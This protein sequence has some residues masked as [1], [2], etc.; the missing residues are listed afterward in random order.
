[1]VNLMGV[2]E[3]EM[4]TVFALPE[5]PGENLKV[6]SLKWVLVLFKVNGKGDNLH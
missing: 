3:R 1:M 6:V 4:S 5:I 2:A